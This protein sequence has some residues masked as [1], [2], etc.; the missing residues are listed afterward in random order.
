MIDVVTTEPIFTVPFL[1]L[2]VDDW[3]E[4]KEDILKLCIDKNLELRK[5]DFVNS[6]Y[7]LLIDNK[8]PNY[9]ERVG[10]I[11]KQEIKTFNE[12]FN[13][14]YKIKNSWF[15]KASKEQHHTVHNHGMTGFSSVCFVEYDENVHTPTKFISPYSNFVNGSCLDHSPKNVIEGSLIFFPS[16]I[17]HYTHPNNNNNT[18][19]ILS[20]NLV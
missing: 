8:L 10:E 1:H 14:N 18:R 7:H 4:K 11:L 12:I 13:V 5:D 2:R 6:D 3:S 16:A 15:E 17:L 9:S 19:T 20:F